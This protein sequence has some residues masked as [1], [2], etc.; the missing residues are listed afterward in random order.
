[1]VY[2]SRLSY[3]RSG[4][5]SLLS[6]ATLQTVSVIPSAPKTGINRVDKRRPIDDPYVDSV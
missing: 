1:M 5:V 6:N 4:N 3:C 2:D